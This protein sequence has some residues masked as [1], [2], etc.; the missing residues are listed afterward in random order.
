MDPDPAE[1]NRIEAKHRIVHHK[2][3]LLWP[4][5]T[6]RTVQV[7]HGQTQLEIVSSATEVQISQWTIRTMRTIREMNG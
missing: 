1:A 5:R 6:L 3:K 4:L 7:S 2:T